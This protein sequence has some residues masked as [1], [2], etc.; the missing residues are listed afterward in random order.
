MSQTEA[1]GIRKNLFGEPQ[2]YVNPFAQNIAHINHADNSA[3]EKLP[4]VEYDID[5]GPHEYDGD[6]SNMLEDVTFTA[7]NRPL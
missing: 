5:Y 3:I 7:E 4:R 2:K 6:Y 1:N